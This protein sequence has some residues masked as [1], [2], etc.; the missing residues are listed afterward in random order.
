M[1]WLVGCYERLRSLPS[2]PRLL[3]IAGVW[4]LFV[5]LIYLLCLRFFVPRLHC[6]HVLRVL[7]VVRE[8][9]FGISLGTASLEI[10]AAGFQPALLCC[11]P[12]PDSRGEPR[13]CTRQSGCFPLWWIS[14]AAFCRTL[15]VGS[16]IHV[17]CNWRSGG[18]QRLHTFIAFIGTLCCA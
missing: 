14:L 15:A 18:T 6:L 8:T 10:G 13:C 11:S 3:A 16:D 4:A 2:T 7:P 9:N 17:A 5:S 1:D 12:R